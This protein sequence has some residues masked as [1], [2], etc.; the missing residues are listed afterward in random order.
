MPK[1]IGLFQSQFRVDRCVAELELHGFTAAEVGLVLFSARPRKPKGLIDW[2]TS[3]GLFGD[4]MDQSDGVSV[5]DGMTVAASIGALWGVVWGS[6][7]ALGPITWGFI[8]LLGGGVVG[9]LLDLLIPERRAARYETRQQKG[10]IQVEVT[11]PDPERSR[12]A[13]SIIERNKPDQMADI[14]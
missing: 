1:V 7:L 5:M 11:A 9:L 13:R 10:L 8:G 4:T 14:P 3:G 12:Q 6:R 2:I